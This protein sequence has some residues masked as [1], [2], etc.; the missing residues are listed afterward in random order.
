MF[1]NFMQNNS[2]GSYEVT[3]AA[4]HELVIEADSPEQ[5]N[6]K[7][8]SIIQFDK[9][10]SCCGD[11][12]TRVWRG[13][14]PAPTAY[15]EK[16][17]FDAFPLTL[18]SLDFPSCTKEYIVDVYYKDGSHRRVEYNVAA[19]KKQAKAHQRS[20]GEK[21]WGV[22]FNTFGVGPVFE[23]VRSNRIGGWWDESGNRMIKGNGLHINEGYGSFGSI[24]KKEVQKFAREYRAARKFMQAQVRSYAKEANSKAASAYAK[25]VSPKL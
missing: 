3:S 11:R 9:G 25:L 10:C 23:A 4:G 19:L 17:A 1:F 7:A 14:T 20:T 16:D 2:H 22:C 8:A 24:D 6:E 12:W 18:D 21:L 15:Y 5:A 13:G